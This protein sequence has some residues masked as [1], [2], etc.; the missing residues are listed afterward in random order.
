MPKKVQES[1]KKGN[2]GQKMKKYF[3]HEDLLHWNLIFWFGEWQREDSNLIKT[4][5]TILNRL[6]SKLDLSKLEYPI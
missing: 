5:E 4:I 2:G 3:S 6:E 1:K